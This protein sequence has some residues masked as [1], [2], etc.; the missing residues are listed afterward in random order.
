MGIFEQLFRRKQ[1]VTSKDLKVALL[2]LRRDGRKKQLELRKLAT[3]RGKLIDRIKQARREGNPI[4]IDVL[5]E[6]LKQLRVDSAYAKRDAK[7]ISLESIGLTRYHRGL[8]R[9]EKAN[10]ETR[11]QDLLA[12][13]RT[14]GLEEKLRGQQVD[15]DA[16]L[17]ELNAT[18]EDIGLELDSQEIEEDDPEKARFL[19]DIDAINLAEEAGELDQ[20][21][22]KEQ[23]LS[24]RLEENEMSTEE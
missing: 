19:Q 24:R 8:A 21:F 22:E 11:I 13:V 1:Q 17:D 10:D 6:E 9:L 18:L 16:Y 4:E 12:R 15:E 2:G 20:A 5:W 7:I 23:D 3:K 14:S